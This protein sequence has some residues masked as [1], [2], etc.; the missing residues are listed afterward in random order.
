MAT[1]NIYKPTE[2]ENI[3]FK[4][5]RSTD[6][7]FYKGEKS[8][9][10]TL[11][12]N[13]K[14]NGRIGDKTLLVI[15]PY[16]AHVPD[17]QRKAVLSDA[18]EIGQNYDPYQWELPK[19]I[20]INGKLVIADGMHR[21]LGAV[22]G[23]LPDVVV[24]IIELSEAEAIELFVKQSENRKKMTPEDKFTAYL[25]LNNKDYVEFFNICQA[26]K[27]Q[28]KGR[29][30]LLEY[31]GTVTAIIDGIRM[32]KE[33]LERIFTLIEKLKWNDIKVSKLTPSKAPW[34]SKVIR[35]F[36]RLYV[37]YGDRIDLM[38]EALVKKCKGV[39]YYIDNNSGL[40]Q[41]KI[42]DTLN[43]IIEKELTRKVAPFSKAL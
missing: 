4:E 14:R 2:V 13:A 9:I 41:Y 38:E 35:S 34:G 15:P 18:K 3:F 8:I 43:E 40:S 42:L 27:I 26:H 33:T 11:L 24:E 37:H 7:D 20:C 36:K 32:D 25:K 19:L 10:R 17:W 12:E 16:Y 30:D 23:Q 6:L 1:K 21:M 22:V 29:D 31:Y 5:A 28:I 39:D